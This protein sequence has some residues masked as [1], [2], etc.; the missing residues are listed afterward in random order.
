VSLSLLIATAGH[1]DHGK[2]SLVKALTG[3]D[4]DRLPEEKE[5]GITILPGYA[6]TTLGTGQ[7]LSFVDV[8]GHERFLNHM[9][10]G[11]NGI[12]LVVLVIAADDG[13]MPQTLEHLEVAR[14]MGAQA[15]LVVLSKIDLVEADWLDLV[16]EDIREKLKGSFLEGRPILRFSAQAKDRFEGFRAEFGEHITQASSSLQL[17]TEHRMPA[18]AV[19]RVISVSGRGLVV[20]GT[21]PSGTLKR[22]EKIRILPGNLKGKVRELQVHNETVEE[23]KGPTRLALNIAGINHTDVSTGA[24]VL[25]ED[26]PDPGDRIWIASF[27]SVR[28]L[29]RSLSFPVKGLLHSGTLFVEAQIQ[30]LHED[31][32]PQWDAPLAVRIRMNSP[33]PIMPGAPFI[34]RVSSNMGQA[35]AT[36]GG[37][38]LLLKGGPARRARSAKSAQILKDLLSSDVTKM[39]AA[40]LSLHRYPAMTL[41]ELRDCLGFRSNFLRESLGKSGALPSLDSDQGTWVYTDEL[42]TRVADE[43][44]ERIEAHHTA[45]PQDS[46]P[47]LAELREQLSDLA[48]EALLQS[49]CQALIAEGRLVAQGPCLASVEHKAELPD[50]LK[51]YADALLATINSA[52]LGTPHIKEL[53]DANQISSE[54]VTEAL[55]FL[56]RTGK[57]E[58]ISPEYFVPSTAHARFITKIQEHLQEH[59]TLSIADSRAITGLSRKYLVPLLSDLDARHITR[60]S[61]TDA[62]VAHKSGS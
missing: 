22:D 17:E 13:V 27:Q 6:N 25:S 14:L 32:T 54:V 40:T 39:V 29:E 11:A 16:E 57:L 23:A 24:L 50:A 52:G 12:H 30:L 47:A 51:S 9:I 7:T 5:R 15:G 34:F 36:L 8:P 46:G 21:L 3:T 41:N 10:Q 20:T 59:G 1:I 56:C 18:L 48:P 26:C 28:W 4:P 35:G 61:G 33:V 53:A 62:R 55:S 49:A 19:D 42:F 37:G 2:S 60:R 44:M 31:E 58:R 45:R 43:L 38:K